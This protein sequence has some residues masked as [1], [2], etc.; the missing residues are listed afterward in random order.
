MRATRACA[1]ADDLA[2]VALRADSRNHGT[3]SW[4][5]IV[6][7]LD[8]SRQTST[9]RPGRDNPGFTAA[10]TLPT[11]FPHDNE[12]RIAVG[13]VSIRSSQAPVS[14]KARLGVSIST[15]L[16]GS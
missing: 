12:S 11:A 1:D 9:A 14:V 10:V 15:A 5:S 13:S 4:L 8:Q 6:G 2:L 16:P 7:R 3:R